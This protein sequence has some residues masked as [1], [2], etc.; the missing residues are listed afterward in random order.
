VP[1]DNP[2]I[3]PVIESA[4]AI[5]VSL[6]FHIP[7]PIPSYNTPN[8]PAQIPVLPVIGVGTGFTLTVVVAIHP[9]TST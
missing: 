3:K 2:V 4:Q 5:V 1:A 7:P 9:L 6:L 8:E